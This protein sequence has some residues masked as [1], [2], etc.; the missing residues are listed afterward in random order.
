VSAADI[1]AMLKSF[2]KKGQRLVKVTVYPSDYGLE[3]MAAEAKF[4]PKGLGGNL[5]RPAELAGRDES[6]GSGE[7]SDAED[8]EGKEA[9][10]RG[11]PLLGV[12]LS[13]KQRAVLLEA[14]KEEGSDLEGGGGPPLPI[15]LNQRIWE[16]N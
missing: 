15:L 9:P 14:A 16:I 7:E 1:F 5:S 6:G 13:K 10:P 3:R 12:R 11:V 2:L 4:G 8:G